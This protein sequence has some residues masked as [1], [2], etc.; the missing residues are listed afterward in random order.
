MDMTPKYIIL[1]LVQG[2]IS[3]VKVQLEANILESRE[4]HQDK[5]DLLEINEGEKSKL[6]QLI[7]MEASVKKAIELVKNVSVFIQ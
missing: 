7:T 4:T 5:M 2:T 1:N 6:N 3:F